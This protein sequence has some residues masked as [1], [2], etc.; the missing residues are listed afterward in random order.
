MAGKI[1]TSGNFRKHFVFTRDKI[2]PKRRNILVK[3]MRTAY[4]LIA[5]LFLF[6]VLFQVFLA[7]LSLFSTPTYWPTHIE[8]GYW[9]GLPLLILLILAFMGRLPRAVIGLTALLFVL[10]IVQTS[11]PPLRG[12]AP[13]IAALHPVLAFFLFWLG[14]IVARRAQAFVP[15]PLGTGP[16]T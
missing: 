9:L 15:P 14:M 2:R 3:L 5:W 4:L 16:A 12:N 13:V 1:A 11:L 8:F 6:G 7:G 10:Y